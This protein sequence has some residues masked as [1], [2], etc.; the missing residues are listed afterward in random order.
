MTGC[1]AHVPQKLGIFEYFP[2]H[3]S[4]FQHFNYVSV[5]RIIVELSAEDGE[6]TDSLDSAPGIPVS[7]LGTILQEA[8][9]L[10]LEVV[11]VAL[12]LDVSGSLDH[13]ANLGRVVRGLG[14]AEAAVVAARDCGVEL[15]SVH[16][17]QIC[18]SALNLPAHFAADINTI[19]AR[20]VFASL[21]VSADA[22]TFLVSS[23]VTLAAQITAAAEVAA[24]DPAMSYAVNESVFG[25]FSGN[26][27]APECCLTAPL[28]LGGRGGRRRGASG[29]LLDCAITG[30]TGSSLDTVVPLGDVV[31]PR[32]EAGDWLLFPDM[33]ARSLSE[34]EASSRKIVG[35]KSFVCIRNTARSTTT[36]SKNPMGNFESVTSEKAA[37]NIDLDLQSTQSYNGA[38]LKGEID[39]RKTFIYDEN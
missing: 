25:A 2:V 24:K 28:V 17:G 14:V 19:L 18:C 15:R 30:L 37:V 39:L 13:E 5:S 27:A 7:D 20:D 8:R 12:N 23:C 34:Y 9:R 11:G 10:E 29:Q 22:S 26:L 21:R 36:T 3:I 31:L 16:L 1:A 38:G 33:G 4:T 6:A 32:M 35:N